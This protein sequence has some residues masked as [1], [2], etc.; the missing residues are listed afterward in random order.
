MAAG[1]PPGQVLGNHP[2]APGSTAPDF[3]P[4][5]GVG[6]AAPGAADAPTAA[7][8]PRAERKVADGL[9]IPLAAGGGA[10]GPGTALRALAAPGAAAGILTT[11][12][13]SKVPPSKPAPG[14]RIR[15][16]HPPSRSIPAA[17][18][19]TLPGAAGGPSRPGEA[20]CGPEPATPTAMCH[21]PALPTRLRPARQERLRK[22]PRRSSPTAL[23]PARQERGR[24]PSP[25]DLPIP[26]AAAR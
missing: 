4:A 16:R 19:R 21:P 14:R 18:R 22:A 20:L 5:A 15:P 26:R 25:P 24:T 1:E 11:A 2:A 8:L 9:T 23:G 7:K 3:P 10:A 12:P 6:S 17:P 13:A